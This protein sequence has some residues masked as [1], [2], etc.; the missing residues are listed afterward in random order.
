MSLIGVIRDFASGEYTVT[1]P[2]AVT[3]TDGMATEGAATTFSITASIQPAGGRALKVFPD[4]KRIEGNYLVY[5]D[6]ELKI[7]DVIS[8]KSQSW[9]L[10]NAKHWEEW[11]EEHWIGLMEK[12]QAYP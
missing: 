9:R 1:R 2:G 6:V 5:S 3:M 7:D 10:S 11:G 8:Y 4:A 12:V